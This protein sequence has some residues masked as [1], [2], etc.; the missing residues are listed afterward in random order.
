MKF[1]FLAPDGPAVLTPRVHEDGRGFFMETWRKNVF[2]EHCGDY[3]FVQDNCSKS[4]FGVLRGLH[5]QLRQP[6]GKL[7]RVSSGKVWDVVVDL[8]TSSPFFGKYY[9]AELSAENHLLFWIPPGFAH[10]FYVLSETAEF[11]YKCTAYYAPGDEY[12]LRWND[13]HV[14]IEWPLAG[15][16]PL[17]SAK[18]NAGLGWADCPKF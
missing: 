3:D 9:F 13:A 7:V 12:C 4:S 15:N 1:D 6:Q 10:G 14:G 11:S 16:T 18:D 17:V 8:R 2:A 5:Y